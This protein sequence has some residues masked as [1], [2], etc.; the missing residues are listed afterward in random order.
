MG[1]GGGTPPEIVW[2]LLYIEGRAGCVSCW[3]LGCGDGV[4]GVE[5]VWMCCGQML[6]KYKKIHAFQSICTNTYLWCDSLHFEYSYM[7]IYIY[8]YIYII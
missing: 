1:E 4:C 7:N 8:I 2:L 3:G 5:L 6:K